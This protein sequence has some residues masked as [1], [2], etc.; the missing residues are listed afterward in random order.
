MSN[1]GA[2]KIEKF[3]M[4]SGGLPIPATLPMNCTARKRA[5]NPT[6]IGDQS[7]AALYEHGIL[8]VCGNCDGHKPML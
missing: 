7:I 2:G 6:P 4:A 5:S 1:T 8:F 3:S